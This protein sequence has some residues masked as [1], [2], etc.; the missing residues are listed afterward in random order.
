MSLFVFSLILQPTDEL[1]GIGSERHGFSEHVT[2]CIQLHKERLCI[3]AE[4]L[5]LDPAVLCSFTLAVVI[6]IQTMIDKQFDEHVVLQAGFNAV[7]I[8][9]LRLHL[10]AVDA[11]VTREVYDHGFAC[12]AGVRHTFFVIVEHLAALNLHWRRKSADSLHRCAP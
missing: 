1:F 8:Q 9:H 3:R 2:L 4:L 6:G 10:P 5:A 7:V 12:L 11:T